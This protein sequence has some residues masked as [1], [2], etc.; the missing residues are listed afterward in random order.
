M[1][2][3]MKDKKLLPGSSRRPKSRSPSR[4]KAVDSVQDISTTMNAAAIQIH[5]MPEGQI[6]PCSVVTTTSE[7]SPES[8]R[9]SRA[10]ELSS[11]TTHSGDS[12][13]VDPRVR[14]AEILEPDHKMSPR[15]IFDEEVLMALAAI[16]V[17]EQVR[18]EAAYRAILR[19]IST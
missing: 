2:K 10:P 8:S 13:V 18:Q 6:K 5:S 9:R 7:S 15:A 11:G 1:S 12:P 17:D 14:C 16:D 4:L 3:Q 19:S